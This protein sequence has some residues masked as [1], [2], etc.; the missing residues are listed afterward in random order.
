MDEDELDELKER[1][2]YYGLDKTEDFSDYKRKYL[3]SSQQ[4]ELKFNDDYYPADIAG[5]KRG[6]EMIFENADSYNVNPN[7]GKAR[8]YSINCQSCVVVFEARL[9]G[10]DVQ[11]VANTKGSTCEALSYRTILARIEPK[12]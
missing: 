7:Y 6:P 12:T 9:K 5:V 8:G 4:E 1:A 3:S 2:A 10:Y 11:V